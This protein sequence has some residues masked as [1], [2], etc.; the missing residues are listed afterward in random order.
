MMDLGFQGIVEP[1]LV[2]ENCT[3]CTICVRSCDDE[4]LQM[5]PEDLPVRDRARCISCGDCIKVCPFE[6]MIPKRVGHAVFVGGK[7]GKHPHA[8]FPVA[9]FVTDD[10]VAPIIDMTMD[11]Y[12]RH[13]EPG[14][15]LGE[16]LDRVGIDSYRRALGDLVGADAL[17]DAADLRAPKWRCIFHRG[18]ADAFPRYGELG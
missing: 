1:Q 9:E 10:Q 11:W 6:A 16:V 15:R 5:G 3:H 8:A 12:C 4:A 17:L 7:H 2:A 14:E 18:L 13:G